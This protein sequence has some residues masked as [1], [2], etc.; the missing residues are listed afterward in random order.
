MVRGCFELVRE[1]WWQLVSPI[2]GHTA[3]L[4][5]P[6]TS[7]VALH[8][9]YSLLHSLQRGSPFSKPPP[10]TQPMYCVFS[11]WHFFSTPP[12]TG[13]QN[14]PIT[15]RPAESDGGL[16]SICIFR[17]LSSLADVSMPTCEETESETEAEPS[18]YP[19]SVN[20]TITFFHSYLTLFEHKHG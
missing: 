20:V 5:S 14:S 18:T 17:Q 16:K 12:H 9:G 2:A 7:C 15:L 19:S 3:P 8:G 1:H 13:P 10:P 6:T 11:H 4:V